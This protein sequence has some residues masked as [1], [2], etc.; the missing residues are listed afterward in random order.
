MPKC[1]IAVLI[2]ALYFISSEG[3]AYA[4]GLKST[5][6]RAATGLGGFADWAGI[7][8]LRDYSE[9]R[10]PL[11]SQRFTATSYWGSFLQTLRLR[12]SAGTLLDIDNISHPV[13]V[14]LSSDKKLLALTWNNG[15]AVIE[16]DTRRVR[17]A[18]HDSCFRLAKIPQFSPDSQT[19]FLS[20]GKRIG[21]LQS[22]DVSEQNEWEPKE[23]WA[24]TDEREFFFPTTFARF[25]QTARGD[26]FFHTGETDFHIIRPPAPSE[27]REVS[28]AADGF[29]LAFAARSTAEQIDTLRLFNIGARKLA[30]EWQAPA[31]HHI[32]HTQ[33]APNTDIYFTLRKGKPLS[34]GMRE[35]LYVWRPSIGDTPRL[36]QPGQFTA[37]A[38]SASGLLA[39]A[40]SVDP[41]RG[42]EGNAIEVYA[43]VDDDWRPYFISR[44]YYQN[45][46]IEQL[47]FAGDVRA[48]L[49][50]NFR[51]Q[52][53]RSSVLI[54]PF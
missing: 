4:A 18:H 52:D 31:G 51:E 53:G 9:R 15:Q 10:A 33:T 1:R 22:V 2:I 17:Y 13:N 24:A 19:L 7:G 38:L 42:N 16:T 47:Q 49:L 8:W 50:A 43:F 20:D 5:C 11:G 54:L 26:F 32:T 48:S 12:S 29:H 34:D 14:A 36:I 28:F 40:R 30:R 21:F 25:G 39:V 46:R 23:L 27:L 41:Y 3:S 45:R 44:Q 6:V 37:V 35:G